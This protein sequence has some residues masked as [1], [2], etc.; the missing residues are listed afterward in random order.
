MDGASIAAI[1]SALGAIV[2]TVLNFYTKFTEKQREKATEYKYE[3]LREYDKQKESIKAQNTGIIYGE[4]YKLLLYFNCDRVYILQPHPLI[5]YMF[6]TITLEVKQPG[7]EGMK[8][9]VRNLDVAEVP[10]FISNLASR[11]YLQ[12]TDIINEIKDPKARALMRLHGTEAV[13]I[14]RLQDTT[15]DWVGS[16]FCEFQNLTTIAS[17]E[18]R[19]VLQEA[20]DRIQ[21]ILPQ[22]TNED[23][24]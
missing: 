14:K 3:K 13:M 1:I 16:V 22:I 12:Y 7:V 9:A 2:A 21:F 5:R 23:K 6:V 11:D 10:Q 15:H 20:A 8:P 19:K 4:L 17:V 18:S 24:Q